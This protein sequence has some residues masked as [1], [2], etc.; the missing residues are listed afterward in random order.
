MESD[1]ESPEDP[2]SK[3]SKSRSRS[4]SEEPLGES[5]NKEVIHDNSIF[6]MFFLFFHMFT[7]YIYMILSYTW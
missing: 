5:Q 7:M 3:K 1:E 6:T 2:K 4:S